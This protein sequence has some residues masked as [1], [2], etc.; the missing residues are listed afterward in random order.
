MFLTFINYFIFIFSFNK[1]NIDINDE[2]IDEG[3]G[4][5]Y[6]SNKILFLTILSFSIPFYV[7]KFQKILYKDMQNGKV[8]I[9]Y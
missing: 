9:R 7:F 8:K 4:L 5:I 2:H 1:E 3:Y 6:G